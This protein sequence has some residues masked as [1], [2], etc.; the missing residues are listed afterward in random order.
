MME[1][2][3]SFP[4]R[5]HGLSRG[6]HRLILLRH[7]K[8]ENRAASG[9][10]FDRALTERGRADVSLVVSAL[11][12]AGFVPDRALVSAAVRTRQTW[13]VAAPMFPK[14][15]LEVRKEL[16][17]ADART[18]LS[19]GHTPLGKTVIVVAHNPGMQVLAVTLAQRAQ[20]PSHEARLRAGLSTGAAA[21]FDFHA[22]TVEA[23]GLF[24]PADFGGGPD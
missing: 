4:I 12:E 17:D 14:V 22:D 19:A 3:H 24:Y 8:T 1:H 9:E 2:V 21:V 11:A 7:G 23:Q 6:M 16:Y 10:D 18:L 13:D 15:A 20:A 5:R